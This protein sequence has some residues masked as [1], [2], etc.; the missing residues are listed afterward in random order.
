MVE[1]ASVSEFQ[2]DNICRVIGQWFA[3][4]TEPRRDELAK[5]ELAQSGFVVYW[6]RMTR[7]EP[8]GRGRLRYSLRPI[9]PGI[10]FIK[11]N[12][13]VDN[14]SVVRATRGVRRL[15][16]ADKPQAIPEAAID[17]VKLYEAEQAEKER[18]RQHREF[19][20][21]RARDKGG[22]GIIW[23]FSPGETMR[24]KHGPFAG[25]YAKLA[26]TVDEKDRISVLVDLFGR[27]SATKLSAFDLER[28]ALVE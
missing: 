5:G 7:Q 17:V 14:Y 16:G 21:Q 2:R 6:P 1:A 8:H 13:T 22:S 20:A 12:L 9:F 19:V 24:I 10:L 18:E 25:F 3:V 26:S 11:V 4:S 28:S 23:D 27:E 15:L